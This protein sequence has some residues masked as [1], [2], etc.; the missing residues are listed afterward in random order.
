LTAHLRVS[1]VGLITTDGNLS[2]NG[3]GLAI[4]SK[5]RDLLETV[6]Q[7]LGLVGGIGRTFS[8]SGRECL[9]LQWKHRT[10]YDWLRGIGLMPAKS[11]RLGP[12]AIPDE[13][14]PDF[15]RGCIDG[16]GS[17]VTYVDR[18][19]T[20]K[21]PEYVYDRLFVSL[22][23]ASP[24][25]LDWVRASVLRLRGLSGFLTVKRGI[26][27]HDTWCLKY[28]KRESV[29]LLKWI[30]YAPDVP[31]LARKRQKAGR[32]LAIARWYRHDLS[33]TI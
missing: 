28:A 27:H 11:L 5:D 2:P 26:G 22:V 32:A 24:R 7:C 30:Y 4:T 9:R 31:A 33:G 6:Q 29:T 14:I 8:G 3:C 13:Y 23:S 21:D 15:L 17:I 20:A 16:D 18:Y 12:L 25:F 1:V 10:F 19:N